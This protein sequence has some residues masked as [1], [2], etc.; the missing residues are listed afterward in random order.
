VVVI[1]EQLRYLRG[2]EKGYNSKAL[3]YVDRQ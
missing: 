3:R 1:D 2:P